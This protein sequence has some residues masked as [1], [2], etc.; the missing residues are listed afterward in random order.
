MVWLHMVLFG[1]MMTWLVVAMTMTMSMILMNKDRG[2]SIR[3]VVVQRIV[4]CDHFVMMERL[5]NMMNRWHQWYNL[6]LDHSLHH[7]HRFAIVGILDE[8]VAIIV[9][10]VVLVIVDDGYSSC[11]RG[12]D[13]GLRC[14]L[15]SCPLSFLLSQCCKAT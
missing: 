2:G 5:L 4:H 6:L 13:Q 8:F 10:V 15:I 7:C 1:I 9:L 11:T 14:Q 3:I 12:D